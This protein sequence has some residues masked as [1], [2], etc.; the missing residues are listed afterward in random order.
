MPPDYY[1]SSHIFAACD[2]Q[3]SPLAGISS[4]MVVTAMAYMS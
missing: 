4:S 1:V 2:V 3:G